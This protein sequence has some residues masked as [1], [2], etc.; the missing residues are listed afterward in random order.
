MASVLS[1]TCILPFAPLGLV[2][3]LP[4]GPKSRPP[5]GLRGDLHHAIEPAGRQ[6]RHGLVGGLLHRLLRHLR[7]GLLVDVA[8]HRQD[9]VGRHLAAAR[10]EV[11]A[12][13]CGLL[14]AS[15]SS[16]TSFVHFAGGQQPSR[17]DLAGRPAKEGAPFDH[18]GLDTL[19]R[20]RN[21]FRAD[22][23]RLSS[24]LPSAMVPSCTLTAWP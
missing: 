24:S 6:R 21:G 8:L 23:L 10:L 3:I 1:S 20:R 15:A 5:I 14:L 4:S 12:R 11:A 16:T 22:Q 7:P 13:V 19:Q 17:G 18:S 2:R 9:V